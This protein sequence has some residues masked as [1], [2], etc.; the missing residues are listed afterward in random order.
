MANTQQDQ[1]DE[2]R[3][4]EQ[5]ARIDP[6]VQETIERES[7]QAKEQAERLSAIRQQT[8]AQEVRQILDWRKKQEA[9]FK[10]DKD[11]DI[12]DMLDDLTSQLLLMDTPE[13]D[14]MNRVLRKNMQKT[15]AQSKKN[16]RGKMANFLLGLLPEP[17]MVF[18][19][20]YHTKMAKLWNESVTELKAAELPALVRLKFLEKALERKDKFNAQ[21]IMFVL[22]MGSD[23][24]Q[25]MIDRYW[26]TFGVWQTYDDPNNLGEKIKLY[27]PEGDREFW[28]ETRLRSV[29]RKEG[30]RVDMKNTSFFQQKYNE[31]TRR[32]EIS[33]KS[34]EEL[35]KWA[36]INVVEFGGRRTNVAAENFV[37]YS[38]LADR[39]QVKATNDFLEH[40]MTTVIPERLAEIDKK[41]GQYRRYA[42]YYPHEYEKVEKFIKNL[43]LEK[44]EAT[45]QRD[46]IAEA[47]AGGGYQVGDLKSFL[48][49]PFSDVTIDGVTNE[50]GELI[51][52]RHLC[53]DLSFIKYMTAKNAAD[54][55][56]TCEGEHVLAIDAAAFQH[57]MTPR[58]RAEYAWA[59]QHSVLG[60]RVI[61]T[62]EHNDRG[63]AYKNLCKALS[64][65][66]MQPG[67][68]NFALASQGFFTEKIRGEDWVVAYNLDGTRLVK[69]AKWDDKI[70][71]SLVQSGYLYADIAVSAREKHL[72]NLIKKAEARDDFVDAMGDD[73]KKALGDLGDILMSAMESPM[74]SLGDTL[75]RLEVKK[76]TIDLEE[77]I[78]ENESIRE[79]DKGIPIYINSAT[80]A[81]AKKSGLTDDFTQSLIEEIAK[82]EYLNF[83]NKTVTDE[84]GEPMFDLLVKRFT[85]SSGNPLKPEEIE[86]L[87]P[88]ID[89]NQIK[90]KARVKDKQKSSKLYEEMVDEKQDRIEWLLPKANEIIRKAILTQVVQ[91]VVKQTVRAE[92][93]RYIAH[94]DF[95]VAL[96]ELEKCTVA[97][98]RSKSDIAGQELAKAG[99]LKKALLRQVA[100]NSSAL[101]SAGYKALDEKKLSD[102]PSIKKGKN[103]SGKEVFTLAQEVLGAKINISNKTIDINGDTLV[104]DIRGKI[105]S[106]V[107]SWQAILSR[108]QKRIDAIYEPQKE[109]AKP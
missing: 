11:I 19:F 69:I 85:E 77:L 12:Y 49:D 38:M 90:E 22:A 46:L 51:K 96:V 23:M 2:E 84:N 10:K 33:L 1:S 67:Y 5:D 17:G 66:G 15:R 60:A 108:I 106:V 57:M 62:G 68:R 80:R 76:N 86:E 59:N 21:V 71:A 107:L 3:Q 98:L 53:A 16:K 14:K 20:P 43:E 63:D 82:E 58:R 7:R 93:K 28:F 4:P 83:I 87:L 75:D 99:E 105:D 72:E 30:N 73:R 74:P 32:L 97:E 47:L 9:K 40:R 52:E 103:K 55:R 34:K 50:R 37:P 41:I 92:Y 54:T 94:D 26:E 100:F 79:I 24:T 35:A 70:G 45:Q 81:E 104:G 13:E 27:G 64:P 25:E 36:D 88:R 95:D 101:G 29:A 102:I 8:E 91:R 109:V 65:E 61:A 39:E 31:N 44:S 6:D 18:S 78:D 89:L 48:L 56:I 42:R